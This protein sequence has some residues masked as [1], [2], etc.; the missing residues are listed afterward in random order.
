MKGNLTTIFRHP[1]KGV[2]R[3]VE[4]VVDGTFVKHTAAEYPAWSHHNLTQIYQP[5]VNEF[6]PA[7]RAD[8]PW[9]PTFAAVAV[10]D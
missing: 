9:L 10:V 1:E 5:N 7:Y 8:N 2:Y 3:I 6:V 4:S